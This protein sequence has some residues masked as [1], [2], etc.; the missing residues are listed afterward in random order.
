MKP[1]YRII[2]ISLCFIPVLSCLKETP[3]EGEFEPQVFIYGYLINNT[4]NIK[5]TIQKTV[6]V[7]TTTL[8]P[9]N[10]AS[11]FLYTEDPDGT[12]RLV[13]D[14]FRVSEGVYLSTDAVIGL[15]GNKYWIEVT[16]ADGTTYESVHEPLKEPVQ[17]KTISKVNGYPRVI[18]S[19]PG[20]ETNFYQVH[21]T[22]YSNGNLISEVFELSN[23]VL[24]NGNENAYI[25]TFTSG[26]DILG[27][28]LS[29]LNFH[30]YEYYV[31]AHEQYDNQVDFGDPE[32]TEPFLVFSK[33]PIN[34][35]GNIRNITTDRKALGFFGVFSFSYQEVSF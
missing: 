7:N 22:F 25:E 32:T 4:D 12:V 15:I 23:D 5:I 27:V 8:D 30:T 14:D 26:G 11:V 34:L 19:D 6:P 18:F 28:S 1:L 24:F 29:N 9:I 21:F 10:D 20:N 16:L 2:L 17:I 31:A 33:P 3:L 13:T 35:V